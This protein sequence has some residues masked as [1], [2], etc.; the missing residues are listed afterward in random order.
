MC[1]SV[2]LYGGWS[3]N[4]SLL[5]PASFSLFVCLSLSV[6]FV[7][8]YLCSLSSLVSVSVAYEVAVFLTTGIVISAFGK[9]C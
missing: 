1:V 5:L 7:Y 4:R 8:M 6:D 3:V 9:Y 2:C